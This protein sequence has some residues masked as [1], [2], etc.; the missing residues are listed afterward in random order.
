MIGHP[1][2]A[3]AEEEKM[4]GDAGARGGACRW[5]GYRFRPEWL[6]SLAVAL[7]IPLFIHLG[8]WQAGKAERK[9][10]WQATL[11]ERLALPP[12]PLPHGLEDPEAL[13][14]LRVRLRGEYD[15]AHTLLLDNQV[16]QGRAGFHVLT[17]L[18][19][20][21]G[22]RPILINRGWVPFSGDRT[23]L[24]Q[25]DTPPGPVELTGHLL[26]LPGHRV[27][28]EYLPEPGAWPLVW[29]GADLARLRAV[30]PG[31]PPALVRLDADSGG[32]GYL[33][34][35]ERP[36]ERI[37]MH[38]SYAVQWFLFATGLAVAWLVLSFRRPPR[39]A[40]GER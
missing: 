7:L 11:E 37:A 10:A 14:Y 19:L 17:A 23:R 12:Q 38:R 21:H 25:I 40:G 5:R 24:P 32:G 8:L 15:P 35:W 6:P 3:D 20:E 33:R 16:Q 13:R 28:A 4:A 18:R 39:Q 31:L 30:I 9:G 29:Q 1:A 26:P 27:A 2:P 34:D 22:D 36:D